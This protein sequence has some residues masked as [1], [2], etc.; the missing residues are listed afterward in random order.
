MLRVERYELGD[1]VVVTM[2]CEETYHSFYTGTDPGIFW[3]G[4]H[5]EWVARDEGKVVKVKNW[6]CD[7]YGGKDT[8]CYSLVD[9]QGERLGY[10]YPWW[11][12]TPYTDKPEWEV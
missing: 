7:S 9:E 6:Y 11:M 12:L 4:I 5:R 10:V 8:Y 3:F 2:P 1:K